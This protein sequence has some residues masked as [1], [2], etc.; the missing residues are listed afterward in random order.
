[1]AEGGYYWNGGIFVGRVD[2]M[3]AEIERQ[4]PDMY[5]RLKVIAS[6]LDTPAADDVLAAQWQHMP[7]VSIDYG[8]MEHAE[9][10]AVV[11]L[12]AGWNDVGSWD[13]LETVLEQ[14][15]QGNSIAKGE[16]LLL[17]SSNNIVYSDKRLVALINVNDLVVVDTGDT[18]LIGDKANMQRV[19]D[20]VE[21]LRAQ[22]RTE[23]L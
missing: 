20:V 21:K 11:P 5:A 16:V 4:L 22:G 8:V 7:S 9:R 14:D 23:L 12:Q 3:L 2:R 15:E 19:K 1:L 6:A 10:V 17:D 13:A 18:L